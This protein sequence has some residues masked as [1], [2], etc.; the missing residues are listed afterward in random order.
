VRLDADDRFELHVGGLHAVFILVFWATVLEING[1]GF[2]VF[3]Q[4]WG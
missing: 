2:L 3:C 4:K 1:Y